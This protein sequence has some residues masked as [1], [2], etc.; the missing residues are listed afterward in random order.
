MIDPRP[1]TAPVTPVASPRAVVAADTAEPMFQLVKRADLS[2]AEVEDLAARALEVTVLWQGAVLQVSHLQEGE[3]FALSSEASDLRATG[4]FV[5]DAARLDAPRVTLVQRGP[6]GARFIFPAGTDGAVEMDGERRALE[7]LAHAGIARPAAGGGLEVT[8]LPDGRYT[9][10]VAGLTVAA[11]VVAAGRKTVA[12]R[13]RDP[14]LA[15]VGAGVSL[16]VAAL[17]AVARFAAADDGLLSA[18]DHSARMEDLRRFVMAQSARVEPAPEAPAEAAAAA[19]AGA[20]HAGAAGAMGRR[21]MAHTGRRYEMPRRAPTPS[22]VRPQ[23]AREQVAERGI[24]QALGAPGARAA[25]TDG[26][27]SMFGAMVASGE[28][29]RMAHGNLNGAEVGDSGG[30]GGLDTLGSG[31]GGG[32][33]GEGT[34]G[35]GPL[36]TVGHGDCVGEHCRHGANV[37]NRLRE[38][39]PSGPRVQPRTPEVTGI[40][41][42]IIRRVVRRNLAQVNHC[43]EQGLAVQPGLQGRVSVRFVIGSAGSVLGAQVAQDD[44]GNASVGQCITRAVQRWNFDLPPNTGAVTVTYPFSLMPAD[45]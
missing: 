41:P 29:D 39:P 16:A 17:V 44:L 14:V 19:P 35:T 27:Q 26:V 40:S 4:R 34:V 33:D 5:V 10:D 13:R 23:T 8:L 20:A 43:Y 42:E 1:A 2:P 21:D 3:D 12:A 28:G 15:T 24:F 38:R 45:G 25:Q 9:V 37:G 6:E 11:R 18:D 22:L 30:L 31:W 32:G 7:D 36:G